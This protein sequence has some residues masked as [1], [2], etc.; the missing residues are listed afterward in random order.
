M[1]CDVKPDMRALFDRIDAAADAVTAAESLPG[2]ALGV[3]KDGRLVHSY[4]VGE[5]RLGGGETPT[6][7]TIFRIASMTKSFTAAA[8][9][10]LRDRGALALDDPMT[11]YLPWTREVATPDGVPIT[12]RDL[13]TMNAGFPTD[14]PWGDRHESTPLAAFDA[15]VARGVSFTHAPRTGFRYSNLGYALLGRIV[16]VVAGADYREFVARELLTPL[17]MHS[18]GFDSAAVDEARRAQGYATFAS[19]LVAEPP[20]AA[21]AFSPMGG[22]HS[23]VNDLAIWVRAMA[24]AWHDGPDVADMPLRRASRREMQEGRTHVNTE[25][26]PDADGHGAKTITRL[27]G[28]GLG[29]EIDSRL[30]TF[31]HH[32]GG[33][34]GFGS[35]MRWHPASGWAI[36]ALSNR[37]Y[38]PMQ[39]FAAAMLSDAVTAFPPTPDVAASLWP[40]TRAAMDVVEALT[41]RWDDA[42]ADAHFA[43]NVDLDRPRAERRADVAR[44][45]AEIGAF[46]RI[47]DGLTSRSAADVRWRVRGERGDAEFAVLLSPEVPPRIQHF[48]ASTPPPPPRADSSA[49][50][51]RAMG[52]R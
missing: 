22:L 2:I 44:L 24:A 12:I 29:I 31:V 35:H 7:E 16:A 33:Y 34:P 36:V 45:A 27:Y 50:T 32:S 20:V 8:V 15:L 14:D 21:G 18:T 38:A 6:S 23:S 11:R 4:A 28:Y 39:P 10:L 37:T 19:G 5:R 3:F 26:V 13:L 48:E 40:E 30:G 49:T 17:R 46:A 1:P 43:H 41:A 9:L 51:S 42:L 52:P 25:F 47:D